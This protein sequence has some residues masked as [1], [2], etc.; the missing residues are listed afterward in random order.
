MPLNNPCTRYN[1]HL[2]TL[3][4]INLCT[5]MMSQSGDITPFITNKHLLE[6]K[7]TLK[8]RLKSNEVGGKTCDCRTSQLLISGASPHEA[9]NKSMVIYE[10]GDAPSLINHL[11]DEENFPHILEHQINT[12]CNAWNPE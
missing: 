12:M 2:A 8:Q 3:V 5:V 10:L 6:L 9:K 11:L 1:I 4:I 7:L